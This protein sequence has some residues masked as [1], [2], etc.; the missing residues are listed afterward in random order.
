MRNK[1]NPANRRLIIRLIRSTSQLHP[2]INSHRA[3]QPVPAGSPVSQR[4]RE[5]ERPVKPNANQPH[6]SHIPSSLYLFILVPFLFRIFANIFV[7]ARGHVAD[8]S[9]GGR[10]KLRRTGSRGVDEQDGKGGI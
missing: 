10:E 4:E 2:T 8:R 6:P 9:E 5:R 1:C 3:L 7:A